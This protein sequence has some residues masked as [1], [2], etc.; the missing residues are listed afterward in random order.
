MPS[1]RCKSRAATGEACKAAL[2]PGRDHCRW[3]SPDPADRERHLAESRKGGHAK[4]YGA[5]SSVAP[6]SESEGVVGLDLQTAA[7][8]KALLGHTLKGLANLPFD[9]RVATAIGQLALAQRS[10]IETSD[11]DERIAV[12]EASLSVG[13]RRA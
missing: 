8:L 3:H 4:A 9:V 6:L 1:K 10:T 5:L 13:L 7:G 2:M 11:L 12:L